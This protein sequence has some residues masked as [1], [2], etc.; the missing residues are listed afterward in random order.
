LFQNIDKGGKGMVSKSEY[1]VSKYLLLG[2]VI[3]GLLGYIGSFASGYYFW[4]KEHPESQLMFWFCTVAFWI[5]VFF[6]FYTIHKLHK[7]EE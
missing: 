1:K 7:K 4:G 5:I 2:V 6:I 3:G